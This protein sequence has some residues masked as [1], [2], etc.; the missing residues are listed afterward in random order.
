MA[1]NSVED[2]IDQYGEGIVRQ[3][4]AL[5]KHIRQN[6][7]EGVHFMATARQKTQARKWH[8]A[9]KNLEENIPQRP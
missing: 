1:D 8:V 7:I 2:L 5:Q 6:G 3:A 4:F 9:K